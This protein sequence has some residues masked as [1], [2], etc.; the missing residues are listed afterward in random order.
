MTVELKTAGHWLDTVDAASYLGVAPGTLKNWR[1]RGEGPRYRKIHGRLVRYHRGEI[2]KFVNE[3]GCGSLASIESQP[4]GRIATAV[5]RE[6][7][8]N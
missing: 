7:F 6:H 8:E 2:D 4:D 5:T 1:H 3:S